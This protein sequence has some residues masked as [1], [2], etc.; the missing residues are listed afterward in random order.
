M[1]LSRVDADFELLFTGTQRRDGHL[2]IFLEYVPGG[3]IASLLAEFGKFD[4]NLV[5]VYVACSQRWDAILRNV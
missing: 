5:R 2:H 1:T 3:S 4:E